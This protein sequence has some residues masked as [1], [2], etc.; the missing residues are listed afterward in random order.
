MFP[1]RLSTSPG[2]TMRCL[3]SVV[4]VLLGVS[5]VTSVRLS[6][7]R[8]QRKGGQL[9]CRGRPD[10]TYPDPEDCTK[11]YMCSNGIASSF[12]CPKGLHFDIKTSRCEW[13]EDATCGDGFSCEG[14]PDGNY[15]DTVDCSKYYTCSNEILS[16]RSCPD[17]LYYNE[18]TDQCDYPENVDCGCLVGYQ[19]HGPNCYKA[20]NSLKAY[21]DAAAACQVDGGSL[22]MPRDQA[23][24]EF[25]INLKN[26]VDRG[27]GFWLGFD[28]RI[29]EGKWRYIDGTNLGTFQPWYTGEPNNLNNNEDCGMMFQEAKDDQ[30]NDDNCSKKFNNNREAYITHADPPTST[31]Q[32]N[33]PDISDICGRKETSTITCQENVLVVRS[34]PDGLYFNEETDQCDY[35]E[36]VDCA[37]CPHD[38]SLVLPS[39]KTYSAAEDSRTYSDA[40]QECRRQGGIVAIPRNE[41][42]QQN[43]VFLKNCV[44]SA[45]QFWLGIRK[46][47]GSIWRDGRGTPLGSY[48]SWAP[49]EPNDDPHMCAHIVYGDKEGERRDNWADADCS[50][51]FRYVC[52]IEAGDGFSCEGKPDG[53]Y[54][55]PDDCSKYYTCS[56]G[57]PHSMPCPDGL[58]Y[59]EETDQCDYPEN[60]D[61]GCLVGYQQHGNNCYKVYNDNKLYNDA[62]AACQVDGGSLA[63]PRDLATYQFLITLRNQVD[64]EG[65]LWLGIDDQIQEGDWRYIDGTQLGGFQLWRP[66]EPSNGGSTGNEDCCMMHPD[67]HNTW[68]DVSCSINYLKFFCQTSLRGDGFSCEGKPD[69]NY[70]DTVDCSKY[71]TCSNE[72]LSHRSCPDGL[73]FNE[74]TDQCDYPENV[75]CG[76]YVGYQQH[77]SNCYKAYNDWKSFDDATAACQVDGGSLAM[78]R[79]QATHEFLINLKNQVDRDAWFFLGFDDRIQEGE[80][81]YV[82]GTHLGTFQPWAPGEPNNKNNEED[83]GMMFD[84][85]TWNDV[86]CFKELKFICQTSL[87]APHVKK[88]SHILTRRPLPVI[89]FKTSTTSGFSCEGIADGDYT[90]PADCSMFYTCSNE[91]LSH[92]SCP[93]GLY[94]NEKTDQCDYPENDRSKCRDHGLAAHYVEER[95]HVNAVH[96]L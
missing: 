79:D 56:N 42:E 7:G 9:T 49:K 23:T 84:Y 86:R 33:F 89:R 73:Y 14:K 61:C 13:P 67:P 39:G 36:N 70:A 87:R 72:I 91:I 48:T 94:F 46:T 8:E 17:G 10:G 43:L 29:Q 66:G 12:S 6:A 41:E 51:N 3:Q 65:S 16:H 20:F 57:I 11:F 50:K 15:A 22:A 24:H 18:E 34:C 77:G 38:N 55:D 21:D 59:N 96:Q 85:N 2:E 28:D 44:N 71:Y 76:C 26:Q 25:L 88:T 1:D 45:K 95:N 64:K 78:P 31:S 37:S 75:D 90:D 93:D 58:Y 40:Q 27:V 35:P 5:L 81:L 4:I 30:W 47:P 54:P 83:C 82:D 74:E 32:E 52:E 92:R 69:G 60:V 19:Q 63:M 80:W 68:N 62:N 53:N